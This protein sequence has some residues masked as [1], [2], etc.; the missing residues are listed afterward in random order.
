M[1]AKAFRSLSTHIVYFFPT[2]IVKVPNA[3]TKKASVRDHELSIRHKDELNSP[4]Q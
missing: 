3:K 1:G 4:N 2:P